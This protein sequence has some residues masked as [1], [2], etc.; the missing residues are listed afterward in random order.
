[1][2]LGITGTNG[3]GKG[4]VVD[5]LVQKKGF[6]HYS[7]RDLI[8][9]EVK[10]RGLELNRI[11]IG[12][13]GTA[14]RKEYGPNYFAET[15]IARA[16]E[17][18]IEDFIIESIRTL[19]ESASLHAHGGFMVGVDAPLELR[20]SRIQSRGSVTDQVSLEDF[21]HQEDIEYSPKDPT[22]PT[23]MNVLGVLAGADY[24]LINEGTFEELGEKID[25]MLEELMAR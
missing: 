3:S 21:R 23:Q 17:A 24:T 9:E 4:A 11:N 14:M 20:Y 10:K 2:I 15:F 25:V 1:M 22:D 8:I 19:S 16:R 18:G 7:V 6:T 12:N 13:T 5:Y